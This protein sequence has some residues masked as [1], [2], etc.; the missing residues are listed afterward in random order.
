[1]VYLSLDGAPAGRS[2]FYPASFASLLLF[3]FYFYIFLF[4]YI[5][6]LF[7]YNRYGTEQHWQGVLDADSYPNNRYQTIARMG[8]EIQSITSVSFY[9]SLSFFLYFFFIFSLFFD[10]R[11]K[12]HNTTVTSKT[13]ILL[14]SDSKW[15]FTY[16]QTS[17]NL[18]YL[19]QVSFSVS[20]ISYLFLLVFLLFVL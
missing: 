4:L 16:Q 5:Y 14:S 20:F 7:V 6:L 3:Y 12:L 13:A 1:M 11:N 2:T 15:A 10:G 17:P 19:S 8:A 18:N 9:P